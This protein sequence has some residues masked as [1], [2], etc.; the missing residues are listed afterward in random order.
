LRAAIANEQERGGNRG[1]DRAA[2]FDQAWKMRL[3][4]AGGQRDRCRGDD[5]HRGM[6]EREEKTDA[7]RAFPLMHQLA[8][9]VVDRRD[10]IGVDCMAQPKAIRQER[11]PKQHRVAAKCS[12]RPKPGAEISGNQNRI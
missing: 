1:A 2:G 5:D 4:S 3:N 10:M 9:G 6:P 12:N 8:G 11:G 7:D